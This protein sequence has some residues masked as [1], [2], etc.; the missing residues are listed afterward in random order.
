MCDWVTLLYRKL[1]EHC[2]SAIM[3]KKSLL[4]TKEKTQNHSEIPVHT[5]KDGYYQTRAVTTLA[6]D[7]K[8][9]KFCYQEYRML[10]Y[11]AK[12][13]GNSSET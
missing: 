8:K 5:H 2:K 1:T 7:V 10:H 6:E 9:L 11:S 13:S 12:Q 4:K 3:E